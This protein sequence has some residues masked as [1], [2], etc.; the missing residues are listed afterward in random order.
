MSKQDPKNYR[1]F[2]RYAGKRGGV[3]EEGSKHTKVIGPG[4]G[5][6]VLPRHNG[7]YGPGLRCALLKRFTMIGLILFALAC[8]L[9]A[10]LP[11]LMK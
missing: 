8:C 2:C 3:I 9:V 11:E 6:A 1:E 10:Y 5:Q 7:D 4:G